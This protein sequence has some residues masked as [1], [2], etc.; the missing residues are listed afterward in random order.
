[1]K[2][3]I[4]KEHQYQA[5]ISDV[6]NAITNAKEISDWFIKADF[7]PEIGYAYTFTHEDTVI[8]GKVLEVD[9]V[10]NL[11]YT[12]E[13]GGTGVETTVKW[14]LLENEEGTLVKLIH[15]GI[16]NYKTQEMITKMF[17]GFSNGWDSCIVNLDKYLKEARH[18]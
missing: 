15:S 4:T 12:W 14:Q 5:Q 11:V 7:K 3:T 17:T 18:A 13:V 1:M 16:S 9:P 6:W 8:S 2:D 10:H